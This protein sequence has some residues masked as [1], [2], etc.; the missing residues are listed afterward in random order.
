MG[1][2][3][4]G[5][6]RDVDGVTGEATEGDEAAATEGLVILMRRENE[7]ETAER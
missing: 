5:D 2:G 3:S 4:V 1:G 7:G 6:K